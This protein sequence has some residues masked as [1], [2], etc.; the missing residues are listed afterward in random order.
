[1]IFTSPKIHKNDTTRNHQPSRRTKGYNDRQRTN[2]FNH[3]TTTMKKPTSIK[4]D[5][6]L[7]MKLKSS[8]K[9]DG[10]TLHGYILQ[11]LKLSQQVKND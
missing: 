11:V 8:A 3:K 10:R 9:K 2:Y 6:E 4:L 1:L 5:E 7:K